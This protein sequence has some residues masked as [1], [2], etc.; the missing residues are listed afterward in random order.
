MTITNRQLVFNEN[1][2]SEEITVVIIQDNI[3]EDNENFFIIIRDPTE[4]NNS[5]IV[6]RAN[7]ML[8]FGGLVKINIGMSAIYSVILLL[9]IIFMQIV[10][11]GNE[12]VDQGLRIGLGV[13]LTLLLALVGVG[14]VIGI[15]FKYK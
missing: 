10:S 2:T 15:Y 5:T 11:S 14:V 8:S 9:A 6:K 7:I 13:G 3:P 1:V 12:P 4:Q